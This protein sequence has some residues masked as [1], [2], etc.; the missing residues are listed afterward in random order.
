M[1][2]DKETR[3]N[4]IQSARK[5]FTKK[6]YMKASLRTICKNAGVTTGALYFF[7]KDKEDLF[8]AVAGDTINELYN[9]MQTHFE[10]EKNMAMKGEDMLPNAEES[11]NHEET[12]SQVIHQMYLHR[13]DILLVLTKSQ[14]T[15]Y[16]N[17][18]DR[19]IDSAEKHYRLMA[20]AMV[21]HH[22]KA[23]ID[24]KFIHWLAHEQIDTF[25]FMISHIETE[26]EALPFIN[27]AVTYM[28][29]GWYGIFLSR[30]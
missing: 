24:D 6:G 7:F 17:I 4:L 30:K 26:Q 18:A 2:E 15:K 1:K 25:I 27:Q 9:M 21:K 13:E 14:G 22:P 23:K 11:E 29:S 10:D 12:A 19:F 5:E 20:D 16:E 8:D 28:M 3:N